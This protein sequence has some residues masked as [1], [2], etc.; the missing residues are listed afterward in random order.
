MS[1]GTALPT[2]HVDGL[3]AEIDWALVV[4]ALPGQ[5]LLAH[6]PLQRDAVVGHGAGNSAHLADEML[7]QRRQQSGAVPW[8]H[9][10]VGRRDWG[11]QADLEL[12]VCRDDARLLQAIE[13]GPRL[14]G[15]IGIAGLEGVGLG[16]GARLEAQARDLPNELGVPLNELKR[17]HV[18]GD[19]DRRV[20]SQH[21]LE[22]LDP[23]L[24]DARL[25]V[26][27]ADQMLPDGIRHG[28]EHGLRIGQRNA[29]DQVDDG[30]L[31][32]IRAHGCGS[33]Q[34]LA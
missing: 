27:D 21:V 28:A 1:A 16:L 13:D 34:C 32:A 25:A 3:G 30:V 12:D 33:R 9:V 4:V 26:R 19:L 10:V 22:E 17:R 18:L 11:R 5:H 14:D 2:M 23:G 15:H 6:I 7:R 24:A 31:A 20:R 29:A 8:H